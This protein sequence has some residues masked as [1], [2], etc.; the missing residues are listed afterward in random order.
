MFFQVTSGN[1]KTLNSHALNAG[2]Q[3]A[4]LVDSNDCWRTFV[5]IYIL[6]ELLE[7]PP[8]TK[9]CDFCVPQ[10]N[11]PLHTGEISQWFTGE[12]QLKFEQSIVEGSPFPLNAV[13]HELFH[14]ATDKTQ[15][16]RHIQTKSYLDCLRVFR[17]L[18]RSDE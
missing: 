1:E 6:N 15:F 11:Y 7:K 9:V 4:F 13:Y 8:T 16:A 2:S 17:K 18:R 5:F 12:V 14:N 10:S 3:N